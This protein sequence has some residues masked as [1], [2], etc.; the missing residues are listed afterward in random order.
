MIVEKL[1]E[2]LRNVDPNLEVRLPEKGHEVIG[3]CVA[4]DEGQD[5]VAFLD[6]S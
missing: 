6:I 5:V 2:I 4:V 1:I 3:V